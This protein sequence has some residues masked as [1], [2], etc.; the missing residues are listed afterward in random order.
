MATP[1]GANQSRGPPRSRSEV[2]AGGRRETARHEHQLDRKRL[3]AL[4]MFVLTLVAFGFSFGLL[5]LGPELSA[6]V[7]EEQALESEWSDREVAAQPSEPF[8]KWRSPKGSTLIPM[9]T[10][11]PLTEAGSWAGP[12]GTKTGAATCAATCADKCFGA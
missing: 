2:S 10:R 4:A 5:V 7:G 9:T 6:W 11:W 3:S 8:P 1:F 12:S